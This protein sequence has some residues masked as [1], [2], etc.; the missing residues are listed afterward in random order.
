MLCYVMF[1]F[2]FG[3]QKDNT[4][5]AFSKLSKVF[6]KLKINT[7]NNDCDFFFT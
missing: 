4:L 1:Q 2:L 3:L 5:Y 6:S 7:E